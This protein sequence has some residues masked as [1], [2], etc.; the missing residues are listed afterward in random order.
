MQMLP[1]PH[2]SHL[3][4]AT[5]IAWE[6]D[7]KGWA[8]LMDGIIHYKY[9]ALYSNLLE[10]FR[11]PAFGPLLATIAGEAAAEQQK[12]LSESIQQQGED[13]VQGQRY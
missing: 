5:S 12:R 11:N 10:P 4:V 8:P 9:A 13:Q 1:E 7:R 6:R 2:L 3:F